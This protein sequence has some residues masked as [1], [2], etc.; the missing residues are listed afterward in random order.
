ML[1]FTWFPLGELSC[2]C[3]H[4]TGFDFESGN[5]ALTHFHISGAPVILGYGP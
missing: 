4:V 1:S 5:G 2:K 3:V